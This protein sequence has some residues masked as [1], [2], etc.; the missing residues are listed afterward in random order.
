MKRSIFLV[1]CAL[2]ANCGL[3][4]GQVDFQSKDREIYKRNKVKQMLQWSYDYVNGK[5]VTNGYISR[6]LS[7][8]NKGNTLEEINYKV[9]GT[10]TSVVTYSYDDKGNLKS[11]SRYTG[12][13]EKLTYNQNIEYDSRGNKLT[14]SGYDGVSSYTNAFSYNTD[15]QLI[16]ITYTTD[17]VLTEKRT[18]K[19]SGNVTEM[20]ISNNN[21]SIISKEISNYDVNKNIIEE[22]KYV[23][24][25]ISQKSDYSY[26]P[27]GKRIEETK[28]NLGNF[29]Y[30]RTFTYDSK[31][32]VITINEEKPE[33]VK[34]DAYIYKYDTFGNATEERW[35]KDNTS[36]YSSK[37]NKYDAKSLLIESNCFFASYKF[38]VMYVYT[39]EYY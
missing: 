21:Q 8:D 4:F 38:S 28:Q 23:Q 12:N 33:G 37:I 14:E 18:F 1:L 19:Y 9:N 6:R 16:E 11:F 25:K 22:A 39:Y 15:N 34:Y 30:R 36:A 26:D 17:K 5:P 3:S 20:T 13:K 31:G 27:S 2:F 24:D 29:L 7:F 10:I 35:A 32:N